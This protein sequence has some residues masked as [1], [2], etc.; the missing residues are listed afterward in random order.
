LIGVIDPM[1]EGSNKN[2]FSLVICTEMGRTSREEH[3]YSAS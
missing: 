3:L 1:I 2:S